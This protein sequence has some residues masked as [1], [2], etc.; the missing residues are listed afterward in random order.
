MRIRT[1]TT[2]GIFMLVATGIFIYMSFQIGAFRFDRGRYAHYTL[3]FSDVSGLN[4]KA[5]VKIAGVKVGWVDALKIIDQ[6]QQ[7]EVAILLLKECTLYKDAYG[8]IRQEG[9]LGSKFIELNPGNPQAAVIA[10]GGA[11]PKLARE[12]ASLD[13]V[14]YEFRQLARTM[15]D[16]TQ[17]VKEVLEVAGTQRAH[18][19]MQNISQAADQ[20]AQFTTRLNGVSDV[21]DADVRSLV[22]D[23]AQTAQPIKEIC[24]KLNNGDGLLGK[25]IADPDAYNDMRVALYSVKNFFARIERLAVVFDGWSESMQGLGNCMPYEVGKGYFNVRVYPADDY[26]YLAGFVGSTNGKIKRYQQRREWFTADHHPLIP[27]NFDL[28]HA[29]QLKYAPQKYTAIRQFDTGLWNLQFGKIYGNFALRVGIFESTFG[30]GIDFDVPMPSDK[31]RWVTTLDVWDF[32]GRQRFN[33][34]RPH[35]KWLN[36]VFFTQNL[37]AVFGADDFISRYSKNAFI[38]AGLR[39]ADDDV[40]YLLSRLTINT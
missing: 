27:G 3:F 38:G 20:I 32:K 24:L 35:L 40:K 19:V 36:R 7:V 17:S 25:L 13:E 39:F 29:D 34:D 33:D 12:S 5:D 22:T 23:V 8:L 37:Y 18:D 28:S 30:V 1:E 4:R 15:N 21:L 26:Y 11:L 6:G 2:V 16:I 9:M 10:P 14:M 31:W